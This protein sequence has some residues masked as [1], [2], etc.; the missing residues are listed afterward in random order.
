MDQSFLGEGSVGSVEDVDEPAEPGSDQSEGEVDTTVVDDE[1]DGDVTGALVLANSHML[2]TVKEYEE[3]DTITQD[4]PAKPLP[5]G[6]DWTEQL[7]NTISPKKR[8]FGGE[9]FMAS[10][11]K[12]ANSPVKK[13][14]I[15]PMSY[16]LLDLANDLYG[17]RGSGINGNSTKGKGKAAWDQVEV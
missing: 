3:E 13:F 7:N 2:S 12:L 8:R 4:T 5:M 11:R 15:E 16:G 14:N 9:S 17:G 10:T 6:Q 1:T